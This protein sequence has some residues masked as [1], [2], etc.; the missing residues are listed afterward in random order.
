MLK[1]FK[2]FWMT[3]LASVFVV[4]A[5][6]RRPHSLALKRYRV[7]I[8]AITDDHQQRENLSD[9]TY[10]ALILLERYDNEMFDLVKKHIRIICLGS[11]NSNAGNAPT[12]GLYFLSVL[13]F[14]ANFPTRKLPI[15]IA[16]FLVRQATLAKLKGCMAYFDKVNGAAIFELCR[17][18]QLLTMQ[19]LEQAIKTTDQ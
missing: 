1:Y 8:V 13:R 15:V 5:F 17:K 2:C 6:A 14:P 7:R 16:G 12:I 11:T 4:I 10:K 9:G 3:L 19:K 18:E